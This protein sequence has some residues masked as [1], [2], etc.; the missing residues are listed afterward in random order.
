MFIQTLGSDPWQYCLWITLVIFSVCCHEYMHARTAL[1]QGDDTAALLGHL[2]LNPLKQMGGMALVMLLLLGITWGQVPVN[3]S[4]LRRPHGQMLVALSGP[5]TNLGLFV[6][7]AL[8][9]VFGRFMPGGGA[10]PLVQTGQLGAVLNFV[11]FLFNLLPI[12]PLDGYTV[13][14][15]FFPGVFRLDTE[16]QRGL[17]VFL[18]LVLFFGFRFLWIAGAMVTGLA[19]GLLQLGVDLLLQLA[20]LALAIGGG[21]G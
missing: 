14:S 15:Y 20:R 8:V 1:W 10:E 2:T 7:F 13:F 17:M 11:L 21:G 12:P 16:F 9:A 19:L 18:F 5:L 3:P 6:L 4:R